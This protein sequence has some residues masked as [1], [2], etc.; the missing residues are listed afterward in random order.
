MNPFIKL[1]K[2]WLSLLGLGIVIVLLAF[3]FRPKTIDFDTNAQQAVKLMN[4]SR[5]EI[6]ISDLDGKQLIDIRSAELFMQN[7]PE[8]AINIPVRNLLDDKSLEL[9]DRLQKSNENVVLYGSDE[10]QITAPCLLLQQMGYQN[11]KTLKGH[12]EITYGFIA[13]DP[14][15]SEVMMLD[16]EAM[17]VE[18]EVKTSETDGRKPQVIIP[19]R[20][21]HHLE[22][23]ANKSKIIEASFDANTE[24]A[25]QM[26][27]SFF[28]L[29]SI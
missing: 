11:L 21:N 10:L 18:Q 6:S 16:T 3:L 12:F 25:F 27:G 29:T 7:H 9:F 22:E 26:N 14:G 24:R 19:I 23:D 13:S 8:N 5:S 15:S 28:F 20:K 2:P 4:T 17:K 1:N